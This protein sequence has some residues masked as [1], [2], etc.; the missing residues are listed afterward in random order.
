MVVHSSHFVRG[1]GGRLRG[2]RS[3][4]AVGCRVDGLPGLGEGT[5]M[6][7]VDH[8]AVAAF[9][10]FAFFVVPAAH[11]ATDG[12]ERLIAAIIAVESGGADDARDAA[13]AVG[14]MQ[15]HPVVVDDVN[16][17]CGT[18]YAYA[19]RYSRAKSR[20][21]FHLYMGLYATRK[22]LGRRVTDEDRARIWNGGPNGYAKKSTAKYWAKV[23]R[24]M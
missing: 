12:H 19:D 20:E 21:I 5:D 18:R 4:R 7:K 17:R 9:T 2:V 6:R 10:A 22:R 24:A 16:R 15:I 1:G 11:C 13:G 14:C 23:R 8:M 3:R